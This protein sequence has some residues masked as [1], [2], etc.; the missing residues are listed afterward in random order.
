MLLSRT[1]YTGEL[2]FE[3]LGEHEAI[4]IIWNEVVKLGATPCGLAV[5]DIL[6]L[7]MKYCLYGNDINESTSPLEAG[8]DWITKLSKDNFI[9]KN[10]L[11]KQKD[12]GIKKKLVSFKMIDKCIPRTGYEIFYKDE[13][14]GSVTSGTF[15]LKLKLGIGIGYINYNFSKINQYIYINIRGNKKKG[16]IIKP[17]FIK[18]FSL[19]D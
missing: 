8:L 9:G 10:V 12:N 16:E 18:D 1:G 15:S 6:R 7:E 4:I 3:I 5:R 19:H 13:K 2:G 17:P 14:I 11:L